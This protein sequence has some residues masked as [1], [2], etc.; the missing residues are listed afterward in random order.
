MRCTANRTAIRHTD[1]VRVLAAPDKFRGTAT[2]TEVAGAMAEAAAGA[3]W[4][5]DRAPIADGGEGLLDCFG[6][7]NRET[8]VSGPGGRPLAA[9]WRL[10]GDRA[11]IEMARA[12][13]LAVTGPDHDPM[14][15]T[16]RGTGELIAAALDAGARHVIV[17]AGGS[18]TTDGGRGALAVLRRY[19]PLDGARGYTVVVAADVTTTFTDAAAVFAPQKGAGRGQVRELTERLHRLAGQYQDEFGVAVVGLS[20]SGAAG[21]LAGG[22]AALGAGIRSGFAVVAGQL[23]LA[24]RVAAA[25]LVLTGEGRLDATSGTGKGVGELVALA[26]GLDRPGRV[27]AGQIAADA[28][29]DMRGIAVDL[30]ARFGAAAALRDPLGCIRAAAGQLLTGWPGAARP[31]VT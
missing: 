4:E 27:I 26:T 3:G 2:A 25:D 13:G 1:A 16:T 23:G 20:G 29:P 11:V 9:S 21:G 22:L 5:C 19:G 7:P 28:A 30:S 24:E 10:D 18:A 31:S 17:G 14:T 6:G 8:V 12:S 15:A